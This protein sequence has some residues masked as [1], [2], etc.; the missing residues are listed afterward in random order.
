MRGG[1]KSPPSGREKNDRKNQKHPA[2]RH[3][4]LRVDDWLGQHGIE[5]FQRPRVRRQKTDL[6]HHLRKELTRKE[7]TADAAEHQN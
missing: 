6:T 5:R 1:S 4:Q 2:T 7:T 3:D